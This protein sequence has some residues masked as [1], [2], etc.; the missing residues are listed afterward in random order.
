[1]TALRTKHS[2]ST[3]SPFPGTIKT[4]PSLDVSLETK[5][6]KFLKSVDVDDEESVDAFLSSLGSNS[7]D[8]LA[9]F[10]QCIVVLISSAKKVHFALLKADL[11]PQLIITLNPHSRSFAEAA[12]IH[13]CLLS[14]ITTSFWLVTS[15][16]LTELG[17]EEQNE[18]LAA[19]ETVLQQVLH[20]SEK[21]I[22][23][24]CVNRYSIRDGDLSKCFLTLLANLLEISPSYQPTMDFILHMPVVL[25]IPSNLAFFENDFPIFSFLYDMKNI[26]Q[27]WNDTRGVQQ[28]MWKIEHRMLRMEGFEDVAEETLRIDP[29]G[30]FGPSIVDDS[31]K[32]NNE[33]G[34]NIP[35]LE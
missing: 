24:L 35:E 19:Q 5:A 21:Y 16:P 27:K 28:Q 2:S 23:H 26:Q 22:L 17:L 34:M 31:I 14:I 32:W 13:I 6:V 30:S 18:Q 8:S 15:D 7:D 10:V 29:A 1:M 20:P 3:D 25:T 9:V 11:I 33:Q 4:Q 12:D